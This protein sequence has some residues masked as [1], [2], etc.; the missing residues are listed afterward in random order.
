[1]K[2]LK[3]GFCSMSWNIKD[4]KYLNRYECI[5]SPY[6]DCGIF[7]HYLNVEPD[8]TSEMNYLAMAVST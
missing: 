2:D 1:M 4:I 3:K 5:Y 8:G 6:A 7:G